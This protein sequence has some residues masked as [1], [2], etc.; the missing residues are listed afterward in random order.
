MKRKAIIISSIL[1]I[2]VIVVYFSVFH[3]LIFSMK[4]GNAIEYE[5][6]T[7][8]EIYGT[9]L[10]TV[11]NKAMDQN[12]H[13][14]IKKDENLRYISNELNSINIDIKF[15]EKEEC[16]PMVSIYKAG[17][18]QFI[19]FYGKRKFKCSEMKLHNNTKNVGYIKFEEI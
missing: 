11:I 9:D 15:L 13:N 2:C 17:I 4:S 8:N 12:E 14:G 7:K 19:K 18:E 3:S 10:I 6:Y 5:Q 16:V 1:V